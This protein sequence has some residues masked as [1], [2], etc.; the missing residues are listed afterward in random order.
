MHLLQ[1]G[2]KL[3]ELSIKLHDGI[4]QVWQHELSLESCRKARKDG[5]DH[6]GTSHLWPCLHLE[7]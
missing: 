1:I 7:S 5:S 3:T 6:V 4:L 2:A